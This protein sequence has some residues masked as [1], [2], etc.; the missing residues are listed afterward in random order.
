[1]SFNIR[2]QPALREQE[3]LLYFD[4]TLAVNDF[5]STE[6]FSPEEKGQTHTAPGEVS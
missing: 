1:L 6:S 2:Q 4:E 5:R 3:R